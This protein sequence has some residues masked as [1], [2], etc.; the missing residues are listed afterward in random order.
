M[1]VV[2]YRPSLDARSGAGQLLEMQWRGLVAAGVPA[3]LGCERGALRFWLRT[4]VRAHRRSAQQLERLRERGELVMD[5][6]LALPS[7]E[8]VFV[9]N[10]ASEAQRHVPHAGSAQA[11]Q[12][13]QQYFRALNPS[14]TVVANS[15]LV[16]E[17]LHAH[18]ALARERIHVLYP[19]FRSQ[20]YSQRRAVELR[21]AARRAF[22]LAPQTPLVGLITSGDFGKR[23]LDLFLESA[24]RIASARP[25]VRFLVVG[26]K[27]LPEHARANA[28]V[29]GGVVLYRPKGRRPE[30]SFAA[31]D[32]FLYPA[33]FEEYGMVVAEAQAM[34]VP[35]VT[36]RLVGASEC[37]PEAYAPWI[38]ERP[39]P[40]VLAENAL[41][42]LA[43][44]ELRRGLASVAATT[45]AAF[46]ERAY[47]EGTLRLLAL[48]NR[49][50][51]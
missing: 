27:E 34:G 14:A 32:L 47:V 15:T 21:V 13:E 24:A 48:Q 35:I 49:R 26:S 9:H 20:R 18:F 17:A 4:G 33:R 5:H 3:L 45:V 43:D 19:G 10:L 50:L 22:G 12:H 30:A 36:S 39:E 2:L 40:A 46:D 37:L 25:D 44:T 31:L 42:L 41:A 23:G 29:R 1:T 11:V 7:A 6:G 38:V 16:A 51:R 28:L 8:I